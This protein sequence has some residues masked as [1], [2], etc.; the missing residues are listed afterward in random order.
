MTRKFTSALLAAVLMAGLSLGAGCEK[1]EPTIGEQL[2]G[3]LENAGEKAD[4]AAE[5]A[6]DA[7]ENAGEKAQDAVK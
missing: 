7:L 4:Q 5:D 1:E 3:A 6:G 2:D